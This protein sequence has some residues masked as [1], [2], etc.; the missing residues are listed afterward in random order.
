MTATKHTAWQRHLDAIGEELLHLSIACNVNLRE[1]NVIDRIL[2]NDETVCGTRN[3]IGF[4]KLRNLIMATFSSLNKAMDRIG[5]DEVKMITEGIMEWNDR[6]R[7]LGKG[8]AA[9]LDSSA[10]KPEKPS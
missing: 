2:K 8:G 10:S 7:A 9:S 5:P 3:P 1:P 4:H 6:R